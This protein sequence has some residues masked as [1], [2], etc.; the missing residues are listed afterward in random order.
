MKKTYVIYTDY[1][2]SPEE[3]TVISFDE[4]FEKDRLI[5]FLSMLQNLTKST[6]IDLI[7]DD[8]AMAIHYR[9]DKNNCLTEWWIEYSASEEKDWRFTIEDFNH[10]YLTD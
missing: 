9:L 10:F 8:K 1:E 7:R 4:E 3:K 2:G 6:C 5:V